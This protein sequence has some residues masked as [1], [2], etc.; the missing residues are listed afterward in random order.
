[1]IFPLLLA[2]E[3]TFEGAATAPTHVGVDPAGGGRD[4]TEVAA[5]AYAIEQAEAM[6]EIAK[7]DR[8]FS[9]IEDAA[10]RTYRR[11]AETLYLTLAKRG[12]KPVPVKLCRCKT[13]MALESEGMRRVCIECRGVVLPSVVLRQPEAAIVTVQGGNWPRDLEAAPWPSDRDAASL[14]S[15]PVT[16]PAT[17]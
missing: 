12:I 4:E 10:R 7:A 17:P 2:I 1:M 5:W 13:A 15:G 6:L 9:D 16:D 11:A 3:V 8:R 14:V